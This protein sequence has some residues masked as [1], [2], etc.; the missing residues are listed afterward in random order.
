MKRHFSMILLAHLCGLGLACLGEARAADTYAGGLLTVPVLRVGTATYTNVVVQIGSIVEAPSGTSANG[1]IDTYS[2]IDNQI[3]VQTVVVGANTYYNAVA[4]VKALVSISGVTGA[5]SYD[6]ASGQI[7]L[8]AVQYGDAIYTGVVITP[9]AIVTTGGGMPANTLDVFDGKTG[10]LTMAAIQVGTK[11][12]TNGIIR[13]DKIIGAQGQ[14]PLETQFYQF[15]AVTAGGV[16]D[17][18]GPDAGLILGHDGN[19]Y[20][21]TRYAGAGNRGAVIRLTPSG[22]ESVVYAFGAA[23]QDGADPSA[24]L[25]QD[26]AGNLYG[27]TTGGGAHG[28]GTVFRIDPAGKESLLYSFGASP[29]DGSGPTGSLLLDGSGNLYGTTPSGGAHGSGTVFVVSPAGVE[30][31][32]YSFLGTADGLAPFAGLTAGNDGNFYG[33]TTS[34]GAS[35]YG[36]VFRITPGAPGGA[37]TTVYAFGANGV[38]DAALPYAGLTLGKDG[39][40]YGTSYLGGQFGAGTVFKLTPG[41]SESV[42]YSFSGGG[43]V[44]GSNDGASPY[45]AVIQ[46]SDGNL[47]GTTATG[48]A[49]SAGS[50]FRINPTTGAELPLY[51]FTGNPGGATGISGSLDGA[52]PNGS[53]V[54]DANHIFYGTASTGGASLAGTVFKLTA[55]LTAH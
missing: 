45:A 12:Y 17:G 36:T 6:A 48:G 32:L 31:V 14:L 18:A 15:S 34:G 30:T 43:A 35:F 27:T 54:E 42:L 8:A 37:F 26:A 11:V 39:N 9:G 24:G 4:S 51:S 28:Q 52:E 53:L 25:I 10:Q 5:D 22:T 2:P 55:V 20:G 29:T 1:S 49:Y 23:A 50:V 21:T 7:T 47:Y 40:F 46:G 3:T 41:G 44:A 13:P 38:T 16:A 33:T 19:L